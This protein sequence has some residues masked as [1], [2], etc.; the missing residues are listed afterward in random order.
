MV[1]YGMDGMV[2]TGYMNNEIDSGWL[3]LDAH[4]ITLLDHV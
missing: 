1:W 4:E 3:M 2:C